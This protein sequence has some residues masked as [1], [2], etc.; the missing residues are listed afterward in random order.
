MQLEDLLVS[1]ADKVWKGRRVTDLEQLVVDRLAD[2]TGQAPWQTFLDLDDV[3]ADLAAGADHRLA[4]Q[5]EHP[6]HG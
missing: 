2:I 6:V 5:A 4:F 1:L 3:L